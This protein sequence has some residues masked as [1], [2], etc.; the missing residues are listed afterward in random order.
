M[1]RKSI[2]WMA[3]L[4]IALLCACGTNKKLKSAMAENDQLKTQ[5]NQL[6]TQVTDLKK[7]VTDLTSANSSLTT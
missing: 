6:N 7:Q 2:S 3:I 5:I 1:L 4:S